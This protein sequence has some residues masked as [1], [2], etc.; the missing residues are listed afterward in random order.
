[1]PRDRPAARRPS[2]PAE[3][4]I[5]VARSSKKSSMACEA[6]MASSRQSLVQRPT[7]VLSRRSSDRRVGCAGLP[8]AAA[9]GHRVRTKTIAVPELTQASLVRRPSIRRRLRDFR[10]EDPP[11]HV[12]AGRARGSLIG[13]RCRALCT[14]R[15][16]C[17]RCRGRAR[18]NGGGFEDG[19]HHQQRV[20]PLRYCLKAS[21]MKSAGNHVASRRSVR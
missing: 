2:A 9:F 19:A 21:V 7:R 15:R 14:G 5:P 17:G 20:E 18:W 3:A 6:D 13:W 16:R 4:D 1:M 8:R 10:R 12:G 11:H